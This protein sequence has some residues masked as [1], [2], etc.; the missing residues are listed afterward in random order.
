[1]KPKSL[2]GFLLAA[3]CLMLSSIA[4]ATTTWYVNGVSGNDSNNCLSATTACKTIGHAISLA[5]SG[6]A[7]KVTAATYR[8]NLT[9]PFSIT[10]SGSNAATTIVDGG[11]INSVVTVSG[12]GVTLSKLTFRN[13]RAE[14][15]GGINNTGTLTVNS[16]S[17]SGN[18][19][20]GRGFRGAEGGGIFNT[21]KLTINNSTISGNTARGSAGGAGGGIF[22]AG[23]LGITNSTISQN[24]TVGGG[25]GILTGG[26]SGNLSL[27]SV[28]ISG[29]SS[30][31]GGGVDFPYGSATIQNS[32]VANNSG[33]D[34]SGTL[35]SHGYNLSS[36][37]TCNLTNTGDLNNT[38]PQLGP[39]Q[40]NGGPTQTMS[41]PAG[42]P[43]VDAGNPNGCTDG[44]GHLLKTDQ[45]GM[46]RPDP[47]DSRGCDMGAYERQSD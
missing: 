37:G 26:Y 10:M 1:M 31:F 21:G 22:S 46:P 18:I 35:T 19:S 14:W 44:L 16:C 15:G 41:L 17:I 32:I 6:D 23:T 29:N 7:V 13:G 39:L 36:D 47:E 8:E 42:S 4:M 45:R 20:V 9:L 30:A 43:A 27:N 24:G 3:L 5:S 40:Y 28:T 34:C 38:N 12:S 33:G 11:A 2:S 25:G